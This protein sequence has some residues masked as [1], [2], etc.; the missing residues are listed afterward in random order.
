M[1]YREKKA[2]LASYIR[3]ENAL[4]AS[5]EEYE[6][7]K[8]YATKVNQI[9]NPAPGAGGD[10]SGKVERGAIE[11]AS[12]MEG[13]EADLSSARRTKQDVLEA[14]KKVPQLR[15][16][17]LLRYRYICR[18]SNDKIAEMIGKDVKTLEKVMRTAIRQVEP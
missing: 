18:M 6:R 10:G 4:R 14:I 7:W 5:L 13:I 15:Y 17:E 16:Q 9:F 2:F 12:I 1:T 11:M 8:T 3:A